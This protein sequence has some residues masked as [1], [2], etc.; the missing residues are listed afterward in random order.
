[1]NVRSGNESSLR[2]EKFIQ[3]F[4]TKLLHVS[5]FLNFNEAHNQEGV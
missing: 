1:M 4:T 5:E 2:S 3:T